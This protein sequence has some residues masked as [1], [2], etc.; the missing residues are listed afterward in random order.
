MSELLEA[1]KRATPE[2]LAEL[3][4]IIEEAQ[5]KAAAAKVPAKE[6]PCM[7]NP[8]DLN[9]YGMEL[10]AEE[11]WDREHPLVRR[12]YGFYETS[13][14]GVTGQKTRKNWSR[15][16]IDAYNRPIEEAWLS[17]KRKLFPD[18]QL[19]PNKDIGQNRSSYSEVD[20]RR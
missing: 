20:R 8:A 18:A 12:P 15:A 6:Q 3:A 14:N 19:P 2:E 16:E 13:F 7:R 11:K 17:E 10:S 9:K 5:R 1:A 4:E